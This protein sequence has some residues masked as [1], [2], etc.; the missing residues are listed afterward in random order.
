MRKCE[1]LLNS[2]VLAIEENGGKFVVNGV[3]AMG[4]MVKGC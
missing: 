1:E 2:G 3:S 4:R